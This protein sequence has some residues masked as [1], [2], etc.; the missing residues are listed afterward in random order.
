MKRVRL[1]A[2]VLLLGA[3]LV[4]V[5]SM[6]GQW[7]GGEEAATAPVAELPPGE[8][9]RVEVL[10]AAGVPGLARI[11]TDRL[12][13]AGFDVVYFGNNRGFAPESSLVLD[14]VGKPEH[15]DEVARAIEI[16]RVLS[17]PDSTLYL[18][19]T[20]VLGKDWSGVPAPDTSSRPPREPV[21]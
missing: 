20:V 19:V 6:V 11:A 15:A 17:R 4:G 3:V 7:W 13:D 21:E 1:A 8:R 10:N 18:E 9:V 12:R 16:P 14:R 5:A 2:L